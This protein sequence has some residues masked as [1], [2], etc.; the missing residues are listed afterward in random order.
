MATADVKRKYIDSHAQI[1]NET[2]EKTKTLL[3]SENYSEILKMKN[4]CEKMEHPDSVNAILYKNLFIAMKKCG[5]IDI[6]YLH[7]N[8]IINT[9]KNN[10]KSVNVLTNCI[11]KVMIMH[12]MYGL[13]KNYFREI[14]DYLY[15][16]YCGVIFMFNGEYDNALK[17]FRYSGILKPMKKTVK[18]E[19]LCYILNN[20]FSRVNGFDQFLEEFG[21]F[22]NAFDFNDFEN[23]IC[24]FLKLNLNERNQCKLLLKRLYANIK[25]I[26][27]RQISKVYVCIKLEEIGRILQMSEKEAENYLNLM[28]ENQKIYGKISYGIFYSE[29]Y[30]DSNILMSVK[31][32]LMM[33]KRILDLDVIEE[34]KI[35]NYKNYVDENGNVRI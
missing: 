12:K 25:L 22:L 26:L 17:N 19:K 4:I 23:K 3:K 14:N 9:E 27:L 15:F 33:S 8:L 31:E 16:F 24:K 29:E 2:V 5:E 13:A 11:L 6:K 35:F 28:I 1:E 20:E 18:Y 10:S 21:Y 30:K 7:R 34:D 32:N